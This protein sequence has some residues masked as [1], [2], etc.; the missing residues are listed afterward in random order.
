MSY[1]RAVNGFV[2]V[3][4][5][6]RPAAGGRESPGDGGLATVVVSGNFAGSPG[7]EQLLAMV[8]K[9]ATIVTTRVATESVAVSNSYTYMVNN[10]YIIHNHACHVRHM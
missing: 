5:L 2:S 10:M 8:A 1:R 9:V 6:R 3:R 4:A 7:S